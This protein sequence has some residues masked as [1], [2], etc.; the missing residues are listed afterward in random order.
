LTA[1]TFV[2]CSYVSSSKGMPRVL[3]PAL[4]NNKSMRP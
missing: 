4:L 3:M 2:H 1:T